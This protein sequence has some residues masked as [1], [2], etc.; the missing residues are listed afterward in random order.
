MA[1]RRQIGEGTYYRDGNYHCWRLKENGKVH[2]RKAATSSELRNKVYALQKE[3]R[4]TGTAEGRRKVGVDK[5][6][7]RWYTDQAPRWDDTTKR[8]YKR[9][10]VYLKKRLLSTPIE[11]VK[12]MDIDRCM[13]SIKDDHGGR[14]A[15]LCFAILRTA[16]NYA[17][18]DGL[19]V[20]NPCSMTSPPKYRK[21]MVR[22][23]D[24]D[25]LQTLEQAFDGRFAPLLK[26]VMYTG[27]RISEAVKLQ[28]FDVNVVKGEVRIADSKT[29]DGD[30]YIPIA[31]PALDAA[32]AAIA[33]REA[34]ASKRPWVDSGLLFTTCTGRPQS[35]RNAQRALDKAVERAKSPHVSHQ[36]FRRAF[37]SHLALLKEPDVVVQKLMGHASV[38]TTRRYYVLSNDLAKRATVDRLP[39][40]K[41]TDEDTEGTDETRQEP[42]KK[43]I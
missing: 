29:P 13:N 35:A 24:L 2:V 21:K 26:F 40:S 6:L 1:K 9:N 12:P 11:K 41:G 38:E 18:R 32:K 3:L 43:R 4:E 30:R 28:V 16:L 27:L 39:Y 17:Y 31:A 7:D 34:D 23:L 14:T 33:Q 5:Y 10:I 22:L 15:E 8:S 25:E 37:A 19:I 42:R 20:R 36:D